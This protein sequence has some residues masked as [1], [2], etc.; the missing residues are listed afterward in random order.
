MLFAVDVTMEGDSWVDP[1]LEEYPEPEVD[2]MRR[3]KEY[4]PFRF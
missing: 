4:G 3:Q 1:R 2:A